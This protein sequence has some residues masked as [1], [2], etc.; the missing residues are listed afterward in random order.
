MK[1]SHQNLDDMVPHPTWLFDIFSFG[2][3]NFGRKLTTEG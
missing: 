1:A 3:F 2:G